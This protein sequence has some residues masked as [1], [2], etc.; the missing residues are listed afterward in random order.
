MAQ[1]QLGRHV[2]KITRKRLVA[3]VDQPEFKWKV[4]I[5]GQDPLELSPFVRKVRVGSPGFAEISLGLPLWGDD[6]I[7]SRFASCLYEKL[8]L[9]NFFTPNGGTIDAV[10]KLED[11]ICKVCVQYPERSAQTIFAL[12]SELPALVAYFVGEGAGFSVAGRSSIEDED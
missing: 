11:N 3:L 4:M 10:L 12:T 8:D 1:E 5:P 7:R 6:A 9:P 2:R